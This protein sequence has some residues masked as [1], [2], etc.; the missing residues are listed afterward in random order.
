MDSI[1]Y[2]LSSLH[3]PKGP[4][5]NWNSLDFR[6]FLWDVLSSPTGE[7]IAASIQLVLGSALFQL[8]QKPRGT[9]NE[10]AHGKNVTFQVAWAAKAWIS[11]IVRV[12]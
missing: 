3:V 5:G 11:M 6:P 1:F 10:N 9:W 7:M 8:P 4:N 12:L 2:N